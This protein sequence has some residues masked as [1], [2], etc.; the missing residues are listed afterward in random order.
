M[1]GK[2]KSIV[3]DN[4]V[5]EQLKQISEIDEEKEQEEQDVVIE[6]KVKDIS[7]VSKK[8]YED[9]IAELEALVST[10]K[11]QTEDFVNTTGSFVRHVP[12]FRDEVKIPSSVVARG[13]VIVSNANKK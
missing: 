2:K 4:V 8:A 3:N 7:D 9:R 1:P 11:K 10:M 13:K 6:E 5:D 12:K